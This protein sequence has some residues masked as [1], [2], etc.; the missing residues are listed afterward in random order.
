MKNQLKWLK[1]QREGYRM[2]DKDYFDSF[3][4]DDSLLQD[5]SQKGTETPEWVTEGNVS[6]GAYNA[7]KGLRADKLLYIANANAKG[8][9][10]KKSSY[11]I[12]KVEVARLLGVNPQP[13]FYSHT[14]TYSKPL[15]D[16]LKKVNNEL[17]NKLE[18]KLSRYNNGLGSRTKDELISGLREHRQQLS[19]AKERTADELYNK[20]KSELS[21]DIKNK[22]KIVSR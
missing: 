7:V 12:S 16:H 22:L 10:T 5:D 20:F 11:Q 3:L 14:T 6:L 2:N 1:L 21:L 19:K 17:L 18:S 13:L 15:L 4:Q 9:F 8:D